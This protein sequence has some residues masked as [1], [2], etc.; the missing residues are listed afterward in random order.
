MNDEQQNLA[1]AEEIQTAYLLGVEQ[2]KASANIRLARALDLLKELR[3]WVYCNAF[4][5]ADVCESCGR[6]RDWTNR[7]N[8]FLEELGS[9]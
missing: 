3:S 8:E 7:Y 2:G 1:S 6:A 4:H 5:A 9:L